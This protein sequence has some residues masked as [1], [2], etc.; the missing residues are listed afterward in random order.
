MKWIL[1]VSRR[2]IMSAGP[3]ARLLQSVLV[4]YYAVAAPK[5]YRIVF[6][7]TGNSALAA[8]GFLL[9]FIVPAWAAIDGEWLKRKPAASVVLWI[10][11]A[12]TAGC[13]AYAFG[14]KDNLA[15]TILMALVLFACDILAATFLAD[16]AKQRDR[17]TATSIRRKCLCR[18]PGR[19]NHQCL[20]ARRRNKVARCFRTRS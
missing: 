4:A 9:F 3:T 10:L 14:R 16:L 11:K 8:F 1:A 13:Y 15:A 12:G 17:R 5:F 20:Y 19:Q 7:F 2:W 6:E 18:N